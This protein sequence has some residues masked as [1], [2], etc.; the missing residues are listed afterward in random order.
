[1]NWKGQLRSSKKQSVLQGTP[2]YRTVQMSEDT[3]YLPLHITQELEGKSAE[4]KGK[5]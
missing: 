1:M 3:L 5:C 2:G 4:G